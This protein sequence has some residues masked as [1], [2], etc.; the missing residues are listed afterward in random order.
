[1]ALN[2]HSPGLTPDPEGDKQFLADAFDRV[3]TEED[4]TMKLG[5]YIAKIWPVLQQDMK[6]VRED[7]V[8]TLRRVRG[9]YD[10]I[11]LAAIKAF[12]GSEAYLRNT[13]NKARAA[14]SWIEDI[15]RGDQDLPWILE[16]TAVA[17]LPDENIK[18]IQLETAQQAAMIQQ[19]LAISNST[20]PPEEIA[21]LVQAYY[22]DQLDKAK[23]E[24]Q[25]TAKKRCDRSANVIRD[26]NQE[27]GWDLAFK[28]FLYYFV[29]LKFGCIK[30]PILTKKMKQ[31]WQMNPETNQI[32]FTAI[33]MLVTD[34]YCVSPFNV[35]FEKGMKNVNDGN[36]IEIHELSKQALHAMIDVPGYDNNQVRAVIAGLEA[37]KIKH[38]WFNVDDET[39][40]R[41]TTKEVK[42]DSSSNPSTQETTG[43]PTKV[44]AQEFY[45]TVPGQLLIEWGLAQGIDPLKQYQCNCWKIDKYVIKAVINPDPLGR[46]PYHISSW[47]KNPEWII[48][49]GLIEFAAPV[50]DALNA[51]VRA[52]IN[53]I[54]IASGPM[55]EV[56]KDR[57]DMRTPIYPWRTVEST[58]D[59]MKGNGPAVNYYQPQMHANELVQAWQFFG[60]LLDEMTVPAYAQGASQS[61]V[62]AGTA[63]VFTQLLAAASRAIKSVVANIDS[64]IIVPFINMSYDYNMKA[65]QDQQIKG[66][67]RVV[68]KG[69]SG[70]Q[71]KEQQAQRKVEYLQVVANPTYQQIL[72]EKNIGSILSQIAKSNDITLPDS[73]RLDGNV[74][75][76]ATVQQM[77]MAQAGVDQV[78]PMQE[79][80]QVATG[81]GAR[82]K[83]Q[84]TRPDGGKAGV[85]S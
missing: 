1:M 15:Y 53:N 71:A 50:E 77:L 8:K 75:L 48:G 63:T 24:L 55:A 33:E 29:R 10:P 78:D 32:E 54:A 25:K 30:G 46:K 80:G 38:K 62:T 14:V 6:R 3:K 5:M 57:V 58:S 67:A 65:S 43:L 7:M 69:V 82:K 47:A 9:E 41:Q 45:G 40:V 74:D 22:E 64:D 81:G 52:L 35:Y 56:D 34:V 51:I 11:K 79:G 19:Q 17:D 12:N 36:M 21:E 83:P 2:T 18:Q 20:I 26:Q 16:P 72:G 61:G 70:L 13:E 73:D 39:I 84:G 28:E 68:A 42:N 76:A 59:Q 31:I 37:G 44:L 23:E 66:D 60:K 4:P 85:S 49:E 27:G